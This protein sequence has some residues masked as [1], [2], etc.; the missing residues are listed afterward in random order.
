VTEN[1]QPKQLAPNTRI[2]LQFMSDGRLSADAGCNS[3]GA[4]KVTTTGGKLSIDGL[5]IT[6]LGCDAAR[7][8]QD[9]WFA[10]LLQDQP[11]WKLDADTLQLSKGNTVLVLQDREIAQPDLKLEGTNWA[12]DTLISGEVA[13]HPTGSEQAQLTISAERITGSTGCNDLQGIVSRTGDKLTFGEIGTTRR[14]CAGDAAALEK[15]VLGVL[16]GEVTYSIESNRLKL[17]TPAGT[18]LDLIAPVADR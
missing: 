7:H 6:D 15:A 1:G 4:D 16:N 17:R 18:G 2:R 10:K 8:A 12:V 11:T 3:M 14:A 13:S 9:D 5:A